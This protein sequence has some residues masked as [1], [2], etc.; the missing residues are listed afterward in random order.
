MCAS[1]ARETSSSL[2]PKSGWHRVTALL[3]RPSQREESTVAV[4]VL[5]GCQRKWI[6]GTPTSS[7]AAVSWEGAGLQS[8]AT[9]EGVLKPRGM[10]GQ[11]TLNRAGPG[12][13]ITEKTMGRK[14]MTPWVVCAPL[15]PYLCLSVELGP[16]SQGWPVP[17]QV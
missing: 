2:E 5:G 4:L 17:G 9:L 1:S 13:G 12:F 6:T 11:V 16:F 7:A 10:V 3:N 15:A 8:G 14:V